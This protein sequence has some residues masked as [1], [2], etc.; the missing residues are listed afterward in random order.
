M[1]A[2]IHGPACVMW[3]RLARGFSLLAYAIGTNNVG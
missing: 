1:G 3:F 2:I